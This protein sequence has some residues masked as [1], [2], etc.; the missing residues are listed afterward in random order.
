MYSINIRNGNSFLKPKQGV[1][2]TYEVGGTRNESM[3]FF[4]II[5]ESTIYSKLPFPVRE[6]EYKENAF[7]L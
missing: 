4:W 3:F 1:I 7:Y 6:N 5:I 2:H